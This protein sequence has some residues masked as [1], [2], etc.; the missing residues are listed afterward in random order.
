MTQP[1]YVPL[2]AP[3]R[4]RPS[5]RLSTPGVWVPERPG[6]LPDL[7]PP[8]GRRFGSSGPDQGYGLKLAKQFDGRLTLAG[9]DHHDV[10][11]GSF[12]CATKRSALFGRAPVI[13]DFEWAYTLWGF[14][15]EPAADL[16]TWRRDLFQGAGHDYTTQRA[17]A[18]HVADGA[19]RLGPAEVAV[20]A[21][22]AGWPELFTGR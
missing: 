5:D 3:D 6:D 8:V 2:E 22:A 19:F 21:A 13:F 20:A 9:D 14:L 18:D 7:R 1:D 15:G 17:I 12:A 11:A 10:V 4:V 16:V